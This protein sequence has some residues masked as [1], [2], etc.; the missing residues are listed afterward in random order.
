MYTVKLLTQAE[1]EIKEA[2]EWYDEQQIGLAKKFLKEVDSF[3]ESIKSNPHKF[4]VRFSEQYRFATLNVFPYLIVYRIDNDDR[5]IFVISVFHTS[6][7]PIN[8]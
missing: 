7:N 8:L 3:L 5:T 4:Q 6:R 1:I 2:C